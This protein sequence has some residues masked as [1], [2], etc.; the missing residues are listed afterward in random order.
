M[1]VMSNI[2]A[3]NELLI[4]GYGEHEMK[5]YSRWTQHTGSDTIRI[6]GLRSLRLEWNGFSGG[7]QRL[8]Q[9]AWSCRPI[10]G[11]GFVRCAV[12]DRRTEAAFRSHLDPTP[13]CHA[14]GVRMG[15]RG[16]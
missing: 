6:C 2:V 15:S 16:G 1:P 4:R 7:G 8:A 10:P 5:P 12:T 13:G 9:A 14:P 11:A 3:M